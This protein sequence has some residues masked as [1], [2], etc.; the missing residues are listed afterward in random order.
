MRVLYT[1][2]MSSNSATYTKLL[3][4]LLTWPTDKTFGFLLASGVL[5][6][7]TQSCD[8]PKKKSG[9]KQDFFLFCS[10]HWDRFSSRRIRTSI[11]F[12]IRTSS[13]DKTKTR[14]THPS[15]AGGLGCSTSSKPYPATVPG[16]WMQDVFHTLCCDELHMAQSV[17]NE[18]SLYTKLNVIH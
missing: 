6:V 4:S 3:R 10:L 7:Q 1:H 8:F 11:K 14:M 5:F 17:A 9:K 13:C 16:S 12:S 2:Y 18:K 15:L